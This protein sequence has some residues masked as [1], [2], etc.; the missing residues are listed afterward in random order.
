MTMLSQSSPLRFRQ[1][2]PNDTSTIANIVRSSAKWYEEF[3]EPKDM[4]EHQVDEQWA[5]KNIKKR[6]FYIAH[7]QQDNV[8]GTIS[9]QYFN[10][11][12]YLGYVYLKTDYVGK[13]YGQDFLRF[14]KFKSS[15]LR[16]KSMILIAHPEAK[17]A[18]KAYEKFGFEKVMTEREK[19][20]KFKDG[21]LKTYY[22]EGFHL[23]Q[24]DL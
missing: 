20:L 3:V 6:D 1:A 23:Y 24:Y 12:V 14:A 17:W 4:A 2:Q 7:D 9:L 18:T 19:I 21:L 8:I 15:A 10:D 22:E 11:V 13:G 5:K 16:K